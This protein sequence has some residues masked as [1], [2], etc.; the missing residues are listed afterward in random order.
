MYSLY[1]TLKDTINFPYIN[2]TF[3]NINI[4]IDIRLAN[5]DTSE[6]QSFTMRSE[7]DFFEGYQNSTKYI[8][9]PLQKLK[10]YHVNSNGV[11]IT[12]IG[13]PYMLLKANKNI[14]LSS[15]NIENYAI[16]NMRT[17]LR[18]DKTLKVYKY[19]LKSY[20]I[21]GKKQ[22]TNAIVIDKLM[23]Y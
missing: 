13:I 5:F 2:D 23:R 18:Y 9:I 15:I 1:T 10:N 21:N 4:P 17:Q 19:E 12:T 11:H 22:D 20:E 8:D 3:S 6:V 7:I 14:Y 16:S